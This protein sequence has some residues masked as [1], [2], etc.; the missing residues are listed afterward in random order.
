MYYPWNLQQ[1]D[2]LV[3]LAEGWFD[4]HAAYTSAVTSTFFSFSCTAAACFF[5]F[6]CYCCTCCCFVG[7]I[8]VWVVDRE[9]CSRLHRRIAWNLVQV[10]RHRSTGWGKKHH[11]YRKC[12]TLGWTSTRVNCC[13]L[14]VVHTHPKEQ[15]KTKPS[16]ALLKAKQSPQ[17]FTNPWIYSFP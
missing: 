15:Q 12:E 2:V 5:L 9:D 6:D 3:Y 8:Y 7:I 10:V 17:Q 16:D 13:A 11:L 14:P 4:H 1:I